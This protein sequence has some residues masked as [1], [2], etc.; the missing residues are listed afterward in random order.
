MLDLLM[1]ADAALLRQIVSWPHPDWLNWVFLAASRVGVGGSIWIALALILWLTRR[2]SRVGFARLLLAILL[3]HL[4]VDVW[5]KP[6]VDRVR[7]PF[8]MPDLRVIGE[9]PRTPSFPS[10]HAANAIAGAVVLATSLGDKRARAV[11]WIAAG[12]VSVARVYLG[13]HYPL[14]ASAGVVVGWLCGTGALVVAWPKRAPVR[15]PAQTSHDM[16]PG[17][18]EAA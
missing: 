3:V 12:L 8:A 17:R 14:D 10:G 9:V 16:Q 2:I 7:P 1:A 13:V 5:L 18:H 15:R 4:V 6:W 11:V